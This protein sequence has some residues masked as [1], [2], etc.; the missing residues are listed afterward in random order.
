MP[1]FKERSTYFFKTRVYNYFKYI[2]F[3]NLRSL[4]NILRIKNKILFTASCLTTNK[5]DKV[6]TTT[7]KTKMIIPYK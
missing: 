1:S 2:Y 4:E 3:K 5:A 6:N 7:N